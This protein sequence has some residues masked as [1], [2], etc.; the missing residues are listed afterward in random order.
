M[1]SSFVLV[2]LILVYRCVLKWSML[3]SDAWRF[4]WSLLMYLDVLY[5]FMSSANCDVSAA[6]VVGS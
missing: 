5:T 2:A 3:S 4:L 1:M 6:L